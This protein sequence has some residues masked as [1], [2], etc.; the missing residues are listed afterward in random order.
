[1]YYVVFIIVINNN[2]HCEIFYQDAYYFVAL[3]EL[4]FSLSQYR[5]FELQTLRTVDA[6]SIPRAQSPAYQTS[7]RERPSGA[8]PLFV[9]TEVRHPAECNAEESAPQ[10]PSKYYVCRARRRRRAAAWVSAT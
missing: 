6:P 10:K 2:Q 3:S 9:L 8:A 4:G 1:M 5:I 7:P